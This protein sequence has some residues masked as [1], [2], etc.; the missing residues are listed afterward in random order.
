MKQPL[1]TLLAALAFA[2]GAQA[3]QREAVVVETTEGDI[4]IELYDETPAHR[5]NFLKL[6]REHFYDSPLFH[7]AARNFVVQAG[8]PGSRHAQPG[9]ALGA[10]TLDYRL[11]PEVRL[12]RLYHKRGA[13]AMAREADEDNPG[14]ESD[15]CQFYIVWGKRHSSAVVEEQRE[16][17]DTLGG[18]A[19]MSEEME[20]T[21]RKVGGL[22]QLD[23]LYTVFGEVTD[24]LDVVE[25]MQDA[26]TDDN[27]RP[28]NDIR[29]IS[30]R[31]EGE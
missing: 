11:P 18:G 24:G 21:Y 4:R 19:A 1:A 27:E 22:P 9:A 13:V 16:R 14:R 29:I 7:R 31:V 5:D 15:A 26:V 12:P 30:M 3:A 8:D 28:V 6:V 17:L 10:G 23:G 25:K 2:A 20:R